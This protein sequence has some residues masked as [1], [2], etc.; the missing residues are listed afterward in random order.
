MDEIDIATQNFCQVRDIL[1]NDSKNQTAYRIAW[2]HPMR[3][4]RENT[5]DEVIKL[6]IKEQNEILSK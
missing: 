4:Y 2:K 3:F 1:K 6:L 5:P